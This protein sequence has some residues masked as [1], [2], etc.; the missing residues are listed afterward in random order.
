V[1]TIRVLGIDTSAYTVSAAVLDEGQL[2]GEWTVRAPRRASRLLPASI[3]RWLDDLDVG[4]VDIDGVA[5]TVGPGS[6]TGLRIG[7]ALVQGVM[8]GRQMPVAGVTS[9]AALAADA[10]VAPGGYVVSV[11][12]AGRGG[13]FSALY[14][15]PEDSCVSDQEWAPEEL[16]PP[17]RRSGAE[18]AGVVDE[19]LPSGSDLVCIGDDPGAVESAGIHKW[20]RIITPIRAATVAR[21]GWY[22]LRSGRSL[23]PEELYPHYYRPS[24]AERG[25]Q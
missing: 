12:S 21:L 20:L 13:G 17:S 8:L 18:T 2:Q 1:R 4:L 11:V 25:K 3:I 19:M 10:H 9:T 22:E 5:V 15:R 7:T 14:R 24:A 6:Y 23:P 16:I